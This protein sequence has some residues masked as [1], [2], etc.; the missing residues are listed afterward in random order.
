MPR[1]SR[2]N[3]AQLFARVQAALATFANLD[4]A[5]MMTLIEDISRAGDLFAADAEPDI[6]LGRVG[7]EG[8]SSLFAA[9][10]LNALLQQFLAYCD[11]RWPDIGEPSSN[12]VASPDQRLRE[13]Q[14]KIP[15]L[16]I[17]AWTI[18]DIRDPGPSDDILETGSYCVLGTAHISSATANQLEQWCGE[19]SDGGPFVI[20]HSIYG[21]FV[22][23]REVP[24]AVCEQIPEDLLAAMRF[25]RDRGFDHILLDCDAAT[26]ADLPVY[27]W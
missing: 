8:K 23:T 6:H 20:A 26:I 27:N 3:H 18:R 25:G 9:H 17:A 11:G 5:A 7:H 14:N 15:G 10:S 16:A 22:P 4:A 1:V 21:W 24:P 19:N 2:H 12:G 13:F